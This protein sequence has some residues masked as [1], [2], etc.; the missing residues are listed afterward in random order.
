[1][2]IKSI[3]CTLGQVLAE[4]PDFID[5]ARAHSSAIFTP[6]FMGGPTRK[7]FAKTVYYEMK[8]N[9]N[10]MAFADGSSFPE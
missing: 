2:E 4:M 7:K 9:Q 3:V 10:I 1:M 5:G 6:I 8:F